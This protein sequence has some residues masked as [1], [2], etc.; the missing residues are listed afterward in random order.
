MKSSVDLT[1]NRVFK[2]YSSELQIRISQLQKI[3]FFERFKSNKSDLGSRDSVFLLGNKKQRA[4]IKMYNKLM[5]GNY[6]DRCGNKIMPW[7]NK[8]RLCHRC[9]DSYLPRERC[10]WRKGAQ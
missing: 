1:Q 8:K 4:T 10:P 9:E 6:C 5:S 2:T 7:E 3:S